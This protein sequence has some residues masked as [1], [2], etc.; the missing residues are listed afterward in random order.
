MDLQQ[1][2][3]FVDAMVA[4]DLTELEATREGWTL[5]LVRSL[6]RLSDPDASLAVPLPTPGA[7][8]AGSPGDDRDRTQVAPMSG[9]VYL[10]PSPGAPMFA[11]LGQAVRAG[12]TVC[13]IEA[14]KIFNEVH[15]PRDG[16]LEAF[17]AAS[18]DEVD[19]G[20]P[21]VRYA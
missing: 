5:R 3:T 10:Q 2:K 15:A 20:Q 6:P 21:L 13:V 14:M 11:P 18:G 19:A 4:T 17:L 1:I 16:R 12:Q 8:E 9:V 7:G